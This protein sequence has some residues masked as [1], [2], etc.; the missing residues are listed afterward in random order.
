[1]VFTA[2]FFDAV[3]HGG[4][5]VFVG[6]EHD[7]FRLN[8]IIAIERLTAANLALASVNAQLKR[9]ISSKSAL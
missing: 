2:N 7:A 8:S 5:K 1:M 4:A 6:V 3:T 9:S